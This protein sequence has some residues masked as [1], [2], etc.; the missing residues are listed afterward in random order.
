MFLIVTVPVIIGMICRSF[1]S[2]FENA[3]KKISIVLFVLVLFGAIFSERENIITYF[4]QAGAVTL[5][6]NVI[7]MIIA[8][9]LSKSL[10]FDLAIINF[11]HFSTSVLKDMKISSLI[12]R[13]S[14][15]KIF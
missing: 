4:G 14:R 5:A 10:I 11:L 7:M 8:F 6:L 9:Y 12:I 3:A 15:I 2:L 1:L 13:V